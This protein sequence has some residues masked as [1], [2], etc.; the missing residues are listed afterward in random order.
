MSDENVETWP[1]IET[2]D[3]SCSI[4]RCAKFS[5]NLTTTVVICLIYNNERQRVEFSKSTVSVSPET[6]E[7]NEKDKEKRER[8]WSAESE[9]ARIP[10]ATES[11][12]A[13]P[14]HFF[15]LI[16]F[17]VL[18]NILRFCGGKF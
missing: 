6:R 18:F 8:M 13:L 1:K 16:D 12:R 17:F 7:M 2:S 5:A 3:R 14:T 10:V 11:R 9:M 15:G 4:N